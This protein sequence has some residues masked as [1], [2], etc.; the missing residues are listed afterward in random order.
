MYSF[1]NYI[2]LPADAVRGVV[3]ALAGFPVQRIY[4]A[5][6]GTVIPD[7]GSAI[8]HR[9]ADRYIDALGGKLP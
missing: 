9:S 6:W 5:W 1:P 4:G 3:A 7:D 2:P 8:I